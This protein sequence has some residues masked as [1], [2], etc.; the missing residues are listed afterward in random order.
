MFYA[1]IILLVSIAHNGVRVGRKT[2]IVNI[3]EG[4]RRIT[5]VSASNTV[6]AIVL[7]LVGGMTSLLST[8]S[9]TWAIGILGVMGFVGSYLSH[10]LP[11]ARE[12]EAV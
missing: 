12:S 8:L 3:A 9:I 11:D 6:I 2:Y 4:N 7:L 1:F 10:H 5:Y